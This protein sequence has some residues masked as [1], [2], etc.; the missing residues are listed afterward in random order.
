MSVA[1]YHRKVSRYYKTSGKDLCP[2]LKSLLPTINKKNKKKINY[3]TLVRRFS[4]YHKIYFPDENTNWKIKLNLEKDLGIGIFAATNIKK[5]QILQYLKP[6]YSTPV[7]RI[8]VLKNKVSKKSLFERIEN[9]KKMI[10]NLRGPVAF[11]NYACDVHANVNSI[12]GQWNVFYADQDI[13]EGQQLFISYYPDNEKIS[14]LQCMICSGKALDIEL[15]DH[16]S[17]S[18][19][20][21]DYD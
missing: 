17:D 2:E 10:R 11:M 15:E 20:D 14:S 16:E 13:Y 8:K 18:D 7:K 5:N 6:K 4:A 9:H 19:Y 12:D 1:L 21:P 3:R